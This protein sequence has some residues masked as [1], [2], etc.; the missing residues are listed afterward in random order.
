MSI[1]GSLAEHSLPEIVQL[2]AGSSKTGCL[3]LSESGASGQIY[4][5]EG[6]IVHAQ[7]GAVSG[8]EAVYQLAIWD[9]GEFR[10]ENG[11]VSGAGTVTRDNTTL[12]M[13]AA[14]RLDEWRVLRKKLPS[15]DLVPEFVIPETKEAQINLNTSEWLLLSKI[16]GRRSI[17]GIAQACG[18]SNFDAC[19]ILYGLVA[20]S[21]IRLAEPSSAARPA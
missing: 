11:A 10:F 20:T 9:R 2:I 17:R 7:I 5:V 1:Q 19:K 6:G 8:D 13:E 18:L 15:L 21:L 4:I 16:D 14:R 12:L 3:H